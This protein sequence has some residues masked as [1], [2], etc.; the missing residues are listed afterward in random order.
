MYKV[1]FITVMPT[2]VTSQRYPSLDELK[3]VNDEYVSRRNMSLNVSFKGGLDS[4]HSI[5]IYCPV[6]YNNLFKIFPDHPSCAEA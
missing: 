3:R 1:I 2:P 4:S 6:I 5:M